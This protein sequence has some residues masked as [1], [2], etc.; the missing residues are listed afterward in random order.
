M[1]STKIYSDAMTARELRLWHWRRSQS[2]L[3]SAKRYPWRAKAYQRVADFHLTA[4]R[5]LD[6]HTGCAGST[7]ESDHRHFPL[8]FSRVPCGMRRPETA[9]DSML[10]EMLG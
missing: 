7:A 10:S 4:A 2:L 8:P 9:T 1:K 5:I 3:A 6:A